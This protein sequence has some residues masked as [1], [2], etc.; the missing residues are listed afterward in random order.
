MAHRL[1]RLP[2]R[3]LPGGLRLA[4]ARTARARLRGL[5][6]LDSLPPGRALLIRPT[7]A[8]HTFGMR[9]AL[10][11]VWLDRHDRVLKIDE[12]VPRRRQRWCRGAKAVVETRAGEGA[13]FA[14]ALQGEAPSEA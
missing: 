11:L 9:F 8:V 5:A 1:D 10:D 3:E 7:N 2:E 14:A 12:A 6:Q 13:A 4:E